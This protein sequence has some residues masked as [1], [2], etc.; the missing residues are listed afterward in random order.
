M[1]AKRFDL[2][3][4][5]SLWYRMNRGTRSSGNVN[6]SCKFSDF[7]SSSQ[8]KA[9]LGNRKYEAKIKVNESVIDGC[10]LV[11][12]EATKIR[13]VAITIIRRLANLS[14]SRA[15]FNFSS[16]RP[17]QTK[18]K[19][20]S[21]KGGKRSRN[22]LSNFIIKHKTLVEAQA[23]QFIIRKDEINAFPSLRREP[24]LLDEQSQWQN[25]NRKR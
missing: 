22:L 9:A 12:R 19:K 21:K 6:L 16:L 8:Q 18:I 25:S 10:W 11:I 17:E 7:A 2:D 13:N 14:W 15:A 24:S 20:V 1:P 5:A 3:S 4:R 23:N